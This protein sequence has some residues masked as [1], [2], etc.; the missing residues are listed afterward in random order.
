MIPEEIIANT[1]R[2]LKKGHPHGE[3]V[4][5]LLLQ[6]YSREEID[7]IF[8]PPAKGSG[9]RQ[10]EY[11]VAYVLGAGLCVTGVS[12]LA[13]FSQAALGYLFLGGGIATFIIGFFFEQEKKK[14]RQ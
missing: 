14:F 3:L 4:E 10:Q 1:R 5:E 8:D 11:P 13:V 7:P 6:G 12:I 9:S 2:K